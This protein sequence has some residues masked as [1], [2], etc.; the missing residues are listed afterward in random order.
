MTFTCIVIAK[1]GSVIDHRNVN[2]QSQVVN[3][4]PTCPI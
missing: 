4:K 1:G 2:C 3:E